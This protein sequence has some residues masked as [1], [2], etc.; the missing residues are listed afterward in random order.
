MIIWPSLDKL[1]YYGFKIHFR[2]L[3]LHY[4]ANYFSI[5]HVKYQISI[6]KLGVNKICP[7]ISYLEV[8]GRWKNIIMEKIILYLQVE[9]NSINLV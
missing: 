9:G 1:W 3:W 6:I 7:S 4:V 2:R 8:N 5:V